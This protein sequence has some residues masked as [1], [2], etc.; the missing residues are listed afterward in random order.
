M[1]HDSVPAPL[2]PD[3]PKAARYW[4]PYLAGVGLGLTLIASY[5]VLGA[6]LGA[7]APV[8]RVAAEAAHALAPAAMEANP[9]MG[10]WFDGGSPLAHYLVF[11][12]LGVALG[13]LLSARLARRVDFKLERGP[14][15]SRRLRIGM[16]LGGGVLV[17][18]ASRLAA[19]C[20]SGQALS[21]SAMLLTGSL[22]FTAAIF[23]GGFASAPLF[24]K[25]W[26]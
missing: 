14:R 24:K 4:N 15:A 9:A 18:F 19:G 12:V 17:G 5:A 7:S 21:G 20:T 13:G 25:V 10:A 1:T 8:A 6:G 3:T 22:A 16:A 26:T 2:Q 23:V 11:M